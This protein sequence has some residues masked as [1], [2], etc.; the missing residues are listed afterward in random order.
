MSF[1]Y[2]RDS[3]GPNTNPC[4]TLLDIV[5]YANVSFLMIT[6]LFPFSEVLFEPLE[7]CTFHYSSLTLAFC[8]K[9]Y[10][11]LRQNAIYPSLSL[12]SHISFFVTELD[13]L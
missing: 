5:L 8:G 10:T 2:T 11:S 9:I 3:I 6:F 1:T 12:S 7:C 4:G 13:R